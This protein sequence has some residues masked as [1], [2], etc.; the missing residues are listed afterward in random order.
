VERKSRRQAF[1]EN[2]KEFLEADIAIGVVGLVIAFVGGSATFAGF[3]NSA[4][5]S[6]PQPV[7]GTVVFFVGL[8]FIL[9]GVLM[10]AMNAYFFLS[11]RGKRRKRSN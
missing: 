2:P 6:A 9:L 5:A 10:A 4:G 11:G 7:L 1:Q 8:L 3:G